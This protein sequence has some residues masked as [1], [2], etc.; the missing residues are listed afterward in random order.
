MTFKNIVGE[1]FGRLTVV[2]YKESRPIG[3][4]ASKRAYWVCRCSC[5]NET[6]VAGINLRNKDTTSCGCYKTELLKARPRPKGPNHSRWKGGRSIYA[7]GYV[8]IWV[9]GVGRIKEHIHVMQQHL[10]RNLFSDES[11]HHKNGNRSDNHI[12]NLELRTRYHGKGQAVSDQV[13]WATEILRRYAPE[14]LVVAA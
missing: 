8:V 13:E 6:V 11:V 10:G 1:V 5:G 14:T 4:S 9:E 12:D 3:K 7:D 2:A